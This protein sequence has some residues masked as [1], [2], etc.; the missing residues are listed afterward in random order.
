MVSTFVVDPADKF[1]MVVFCLFEKEPQAEKSSFFPNN[2]TIKVFFALSQN[3]V[4]DELFVKLFF[5][6]LFQLI[7]VLLC[8]MLY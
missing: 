2:K 8:Q 1:P 3:I 5:V 7:Q 6:L 4:L